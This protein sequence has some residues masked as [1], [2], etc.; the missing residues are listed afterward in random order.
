MLAESSALDSCYLYNKKILNI[1]LKMMLVVLGIEANDRFE[2]L[3]VFNVIGIF[4]IC[5]WG[6]QNSCK[7][8]R[9]QNTGK[10][11]KKVRY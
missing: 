3:L 5:L 10:H 7:P 8:W 4:F 6:I 2:R 11:W 9:I 1:E